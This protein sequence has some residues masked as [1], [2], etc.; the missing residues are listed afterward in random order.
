MALPPFRVKSKVYVQVSDA[1]AKQ[2]EADEAFLRAVENGN[3]DEVKLADRKGAENNVADERSISAVHK[4]MR[5]GTDILK[6]LSGNGAFVELPDVEG[7]RPVAYAIRFD[8]VGAIEHLLALKAEDGCGVVDLKQVITK[9]GNTL[10]HEA[11]WFDRPEAAKLLL[12]TGAFTKEMLE[13]SNLAGQTA[14]HVASFRAT[15]DFLQ[16]LAESGASVETATSSKRH[17]KET[18]M[19][20][21]TALGKDANAKYIQDLAVAIQSIRFA[22]RMKR[23]A[24]AKKPKSDT[25]KSAVAPAEDAEVFNIRFEFDLKLFTADLEKSF[26][27]K[28]AKHAEVEPEY[29]VVLSRTAGSVIL[30]IEVRPPKDAEAGI[31]VPKR[32]LQK[33]RD[34]SKEDL[35]TALGYPVLDK[36]VGPRTSAAATVEAKADSSTKVTVVG[37]SPRSTPG[38]KPTEAV[39]SPRASSK[40]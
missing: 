33:L 18:P 10:L 31:E 13:Q 35:T 5:H 1:E 28:L 2:M 27:A 8:N 22:S 7:C 40:A 17:M 34:S 21:A 12:A 4:S 39:G 14:M 24:N 26:I 23:R 32:V 19:Q 29:L 6:H 16:L 37:Q 9:T 3:L 38:F 36:S 25:P 20:L 15:T 30:Q 11:A